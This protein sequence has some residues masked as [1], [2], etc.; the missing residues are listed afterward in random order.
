MV[1]VVSRKRNNGSALLLATVGCDVIVNVSGGSPAIPSSTI[2]TSMS[3]PTLGSRNKISD[4]T[5]EK[6]FTA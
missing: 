2:V 6:S 3:I 4:V 1:I 5:S